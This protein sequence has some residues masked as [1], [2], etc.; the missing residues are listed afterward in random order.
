MHIFTYGT[1]MFPEVWQAV[2]GRQFETVQCTARGYAI[3]RVWEAVF[4]GIVAAGDSDAVRG[5]AYL[6]VD[7]ACL[8]RLDRFED[9]FYRRQT[10]WVEC[11]DGQRRAAEA[12]IVLAENR[13]LLTDE[14]WSP[15]QFVVLGHLDQFIHRFAGF[16]RITN[17]D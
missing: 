4:P 14:P 16:S 12:Y 13:S 3:Y 11:D 17:R 15:E 10:L 5:V 1:L 8:A 7:P 9:D 6:N 2:V